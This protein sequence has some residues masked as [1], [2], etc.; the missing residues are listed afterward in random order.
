MD[1]NGDCPKYKM[2]YKFVF[3][4]VGLTQREKEIMPW[5]RVSIR[6]PS[7]SVYLKTLLVDSIVEFVV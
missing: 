7:R 5:P 4:V 6:F 2:C 1:R 3:V